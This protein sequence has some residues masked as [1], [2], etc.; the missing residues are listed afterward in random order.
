MSDGFEIIDDGQVH[1]AL[2]DDQR[3]CELWVSET[4]GEVRHFAD[5]L[6]TLPGYN[7]VLQQIATKLIHV[8]EVNPRLGKVLGSHR[9]W[10]MA[11]V[12]FAIHC[13]EPEGQS[14]S[15]QSS[16][17]MIATRMASL[18]ER[19]DVASRN[20]VSSF[21]AEMVAYHFLQ[22]VPGTKG[23]RSRPLMPTEI[24]VS[25]MSHW[26]ASN[27]GAL[28]LMDS[29]NRLA[30]L[31]AR[32]KMAR[33]IHAISVRLLLEAKEWL[34]PNAEIM[35]FLSMESGGLVLDEL[36]STI[37]FTKSDVEKGHLALGKLNVSKMARHFQIS[38]VNLDRLLKRAEENGSIGRDH[39]GDVWMAEPFFRAQAWRQALKFAV[40]NYAFLWS[41]EQKDD[42]VIEI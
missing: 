12:G 6:V 30:V 14:R 5:H 31:E 33:L 22:P 18:M 35:N 25:A 23:R 27:F 9:R 40:L 29:G 13:S 16:K 28:D 19:Y 38:R 8:Y 42:R 26:L 10:F 32:P 41:L 34:Q 4:M 21:L 11:Q 15:G 1:Q 20:T 3:P 2:E 39:H 36:I 24:A 7:L 17:G 37:D